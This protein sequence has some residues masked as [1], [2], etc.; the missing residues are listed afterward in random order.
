M[1]FD[2]NEIRIHR[3]WNVTFRSNEVRLGCY[4]A[5]SLI[6]VRRK[7]GLLN[8]LWINEI[9]LKRQSDSWGEMKTN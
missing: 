2:L 5:Y 9:Q 8:D 4:D 6:S 1:E 3:Q 7:F